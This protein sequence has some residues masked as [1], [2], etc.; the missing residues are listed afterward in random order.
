MPL[1][2]GLVNIPW[3]DTELQ[4]SFLDAPAP[5]CKNYTEAP[6]LFQF[7]G[8][9]QHSAHLKKFLCKYRRR[10]SAPKAST[11]NLRGIPH[12]FSFGELSK[13]YRRR[14]VSRD[15]PLIFLHYGH[16]MPRYATLFFS[17]WRH[18]IPHGGSVFF[19]GWPRNTSPFVFLFHLPFSLPI[20][21]KFSQSDPQF[22][23]GRFFNLGHPLP[24]QPHDLSCFCRA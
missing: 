6:G 1:S 22:K 3:R 24:R 20:I 19:L 2:A 7:C 14:I 12:T 9:G 11:E 17:S 8:S 16:T 10:F 15:T 13:S 21:P 5:D 23:E 18:D 4:E